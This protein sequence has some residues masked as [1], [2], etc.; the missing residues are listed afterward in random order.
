[1]GITSQASNA[2]V[3]ESLSR[4]SE[5][6]C[7]KAD[8]DQTY[9]LAAIAQLRFM[10]SVV[11]SSLSIVG[12]VPSSLCTLRDGRKYDR[13]IPDRELR[14]EGRWSHV[15]RVR[16]EGRK[17]GTSIS[18]SA[19]RLNF[20]IT[21]SISPSMAST[22]LNRSGVLSASRTCCPPVALAAIAPLRR[23]SSSVRSSL[24]RWRDWRKIRRP[25]LP[26]DR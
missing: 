1:M 12:S 7:R 3:A 15:R 18:S 4:R 21:M 19:R 9:S 6:G 23:R 8:L 5:C 25:K 17:A 20:S 11:L 10:S 13:S 22:H 2:A 16:G 14:L 24:L 26:V